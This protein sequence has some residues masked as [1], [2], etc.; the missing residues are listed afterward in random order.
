MKRDDILS[1]YPV[2][3]SLRRKQQFNFVNE[4]GL[5]D[6]VLGSRKPEAIYSE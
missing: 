6:V 3:D 4:N 5:F 2:L 1:K